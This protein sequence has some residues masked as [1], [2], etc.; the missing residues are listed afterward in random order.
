MHLAGEAKRRQ[1]FEQVVAKAAAVLE[2]FDLLDRE[3]Q[4]FEIVERLLETRRHEK[5]A[6]RRELAHEEL[7]DRGPGLPMIQ[8]GL[9]H[10]ELIEIG[11]QRVGQLALLR[12]VS[13]AFYDETAI[14]FRRL[15]EKR[16]LA[17]LAA[18]PSGIAAV[19]ARRRRAARLRAKP[20]A[21]RPASRAPARP[22][23]PFPPPQWH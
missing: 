4:A 19:A 9:N 2:P 17:R 15:I 5:P 22:Y 12:V 8:I 20:S 13:P 16:R 14:S 10:S 1:I 18:P 3:A 7:E 23:P 6:P 11:E 21:D